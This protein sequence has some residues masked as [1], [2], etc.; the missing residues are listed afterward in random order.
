ML[1]RLGSINILVIALVAMLWGCSSAPA[2]AT[3]A[4]L[5]S[6]DLSAEDSAAVQAVSSNISLLPR[7]LA[8]A[9]ESYIKAQELELRGESALAEV[10]LQ[11]AY[12]ADPGSRYLGFAVAERLARRGD[13]AAALDLAKKANSRKGKVT[14]SQLELMARLYVND[15][16]ADSARHY[17]NAALDSNKYQDM[18]L[19]YDYSL[20]LEAIRDTKELVKVYE[21]LLP[22]V[23]FMQ[24][25]YQ[26]QVELLTEQKKDSALVDLANS[27]YERTEDRRFL[28]QKEYYLMAQG[29]NDEALAV[30]D[31][32]KDTTEVSMHMFN[33]YLGI[34]RDPADTV[35]QNKVYS[36]LKKKVDQDSV[37]LPTLLTTLGVYEFRREMNDTARVHLKE[38]FNKLEHDYSETGR[39]GLILAARTLA[40]IEMVEK[41]R[42]E[43]VLYAGFADSLTNGEE[44]LLL[45]TAYANAKMFDQAYA[46]I[47]SMMLVIS[48][49]LQQPV[50]LS[51]PATVQ[52]RA[53]LQANH[54]QYQSLYARTLVENAIEI[55]DHHLGDSV[56]MAKAHGLRSHAQLIFESLYAADTT[57]WVNL[58][59]MAANKVLMN[60]KDEGFD[61]FQ[62]ALDKLSASGTATARD[63]ADLL[64]S[65]GYTLIDRFRN[66][67]DVEKGLEMVLKAIELDKDTTGF[68]KEAYLD[69]KAWGLYRLGRFEEALAILV[70]FKNKELQDHYTYW[71]HLGM[72]QSALGKKA[73]ATKTF[74][75][76]LTFQPKHPDAL[77]FLKGKKK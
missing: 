59:L 20:F 68:S 11:R 73:E 30:I 7:D 44:K 2:P 45:A 22:Q 18:K 19:L 42:R 13:N 36:F 58:Y 41:N 74:K 26:R 55:E 3:N 76:L 16:Q 66:Q 6:K 9:H 5:E 69:S 48:G 62:K 39:N 25:L 77:Q 72:I 1:K 4:N 70:T 14:V 24:S 61:M 37:R 54:A 64:N 27:A 47:D 67:Q 33:L 29:R 17:F 40:V 12:E 28:I 15:G 38:A 51:D 43:A 71:E 75:K 21:I 53:M 49:V 34:A 31:T 23:N 52:N 56:N 63:S 50:L 65:F 46:L 57:Q 32:I 35:S 60:D 10:F 8:V